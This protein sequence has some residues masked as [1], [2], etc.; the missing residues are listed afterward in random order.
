[1]SKSLKLA[2]A[3]KHGEGHGLWGAARWGAGS[4]RPT[5]QGALPARRWSA[6]GT[7][8][9]A[10][11]SLHTSVPPGHFSVYLANKITQNATCTLCSNRPV[12]L[13]SC[14]KKFTSPNRACSRAV[15]CPRPP[16]PGRDA[17]RTKRPA[18][19]CSQCARSPSTHV[20]QASQ[21]G[22]RSDQVNGAH[23]KQTLEGS[24]APLAR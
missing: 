6:A 13:Q 10:S 18:N 5:G 2:C 21:V 24:R 3:R 11:C 4:A 15:A 1:M 16:A 9:W 22:L 14:W 19:S 23:I 17:V 12:V 8:V 20:S 7:C